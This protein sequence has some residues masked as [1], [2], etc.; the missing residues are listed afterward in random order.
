MHESHIK[1]SWNSSACAAVHTEGHQEG[2]K[3]EKKN[4]SGTDLNF[5]AR[6]HLIK[7]VKAKAA[8]A[9]TGFEL[10]PSVVY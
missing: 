8:S 9:S 2:K 1:T 4:L 7:E 5:K 6:S 3:K 10:G